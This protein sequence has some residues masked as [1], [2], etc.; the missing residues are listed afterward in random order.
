MLLAGAVIAPTLRAAPMSAAHKLLQLE[1]QWIR[2]SATHSTAFLDH[3]LAAD[4]VEVTYDGRI[5]SKADVLQGRVAP[6]TVQT[7]SDLRVRIFGATAVV[8]GLNTVANSK[9]GWTA[10]LRF[11][12][13][14]VRN[15]SG[16][17]AV[18]A[19]ETLLK[20]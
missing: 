18:S 15:D 11:T 2:A 12:D 8:T 1:H 16:W 3:L 5:R 10:R 9:Q 14:F 17:H 20:P 4:F 13:V 7:L 19:Q 6:G